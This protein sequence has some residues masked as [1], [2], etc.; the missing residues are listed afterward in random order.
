MKKKPTKS[1]IRKELDEQISKFL[2]SGNTVNKIPK[3]LGSDHID[4]KKISWSPSEKKEDW[5]YLNDIVD[6]LEHRKKQK[7][8]RP[9][10]KIKP[11]KILIYDDFGEPLRW[12]W[13]DES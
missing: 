10:K 12:I 8:E 5:T 13:T 1:E 11:R 7:K 3:G 6:N 4:E 9:T 2:E